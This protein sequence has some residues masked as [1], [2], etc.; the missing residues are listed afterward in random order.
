MSALRIIRGAESDFCL[1]PCSVRDLSIPVFYHKD[2]GLPTKTNAFYLPADIFSMEMDSVIIGQRI[3]QRRKPVRIVHSAT[4]TYF[5]PQNKPARRV[6]AKPPKLKPRGIEKP[7]AIV[8]SRTIEQSHTIE[9]SRI[10]EKIRFDCISFLKN[11][12]LDAF[13]NATQRAERRAARP[14]LSVFPSLKA[15]AHRKTAVILGV[16]L[17]AALLVF[18]IAEAVR[19]S[20]NHVNLKLFTMP[21]D[22]QL[23]EQLLLTLSPEASAEEELPPSLPLTMSTSIYRIGRNETLDAIARRFGVRIDTLISL[24]A[25]KDARRIQ[26]GASLKIPSMDGI[27]HTVS[28]GESLG[29]IAA[30]YKIDILDLAD[31]NNLA[32]KVIQPKQSLFIPGARLAPSQLKRA[33]G[34]LIVWPVQGRISS[35]FGYRISPISGVRHFHNGL[36]IVGQENSVIHA[37][38]DGKVA[39]TGFSPVFG[40][41]VILAHSDG[42]QTL[43]A[44]LN[45]I[46]VKSGQSITQGNSLGLL[47][48]TGM[49]TGPHLHFSVFK[50]GVGQDPRKILGK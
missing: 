14:S 16:F 1:I 7:R 5:S 20:W 32:S 6:V 28:K 48:S 49:S 45:K 4:N 44:H 10:S 43:Y 19:F 9:Q 17:A 12:I 15:V 42:Y 35:A 2:C 11:K 8:E 22:M 21:E 26:S 23:T 29:S 31:A 39:Q 36:D 46:N 13:H 25:I 27:M 3:A 18:G 41:F 34:T 24:N 50:R 40:N 38:M 30:L 33:L 37:A 47:G